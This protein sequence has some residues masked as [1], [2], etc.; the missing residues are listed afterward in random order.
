MPFSPGRFAISEELSDELM[1]FE[2]I[3]E[4]IVMQQQQ[5]PGTI[6]EIRRQVNEM[7][8]QLGDEPPI[9]ATVLFHVKQASVP[10]FQ[11]MA[12]VL[13]EKTR[14]LDGMEQFLFHKHNCT[15]WKPDPASAITYLIYERWE[16]VRY[17]RKQW[18]SRH[19]HHFQDNVFPLLAEP[20]GLDF[21]N[22][23]CDAAVPA[24]VAPAPVLRTGQSKCWG[25]DGASVNCRDT[26]QD[27]AVQAGIPWPTERFTDN[28]DGTVTDNRSGLIW[29]QDANFFK[30]VTRE[31]A[32]Q[33]ARELCDGTAGLKD[34][35]NPGDW[36][37]PNVNELQSLLD[38]SNTEGP[39]VPA[40]HPFKHLRAVNYWTAS[41]V[42]LAPALGWYTAMAVGPPV[43][44]LKMNFMHMLPVK[45]ESARV[46]KTGQTKCWDVTGKEIACQGSGMDG[47][48]Q[49]GVA[50]P[51]PRFT[52]HRN[53]TVTDHLTGL[54]WLH[55]ADAFGTLSWQDA[56][57]AC[58]SLADDGSFPWLRDSSKAGDWR[59]PNVH[60]LRS[61]VDYDHH[62]PALPANH[63]FEH[64][65]PSLYWSSTTVASAPNQARFVFIGVG[66][67]V[68]DHK[69]VLLGVWPVK[70]GT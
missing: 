37:L 20:P 6:D 64:V 55:N 10:Q 65:R 53:G 63:P 1:Q 26:G 66:P 57:D 4:T 8:D 19:L 68:W 2:L 23:Y 12:G 32:L 69:G 45:G 40:K 67:S 14:R 28:G 33:N 36:R 11:E 18:N 15:P 49:K 61:L 41:S 70:G 58:N 5:L 44:D 56:L 30:E 25:A 42:A 9:A 7:L 21:L 27:G 29:L 59:L 51:D 34:D 16:S 13:T 47:D 24:T 35:S 22:F 38:L 31:Q 54:I 48:L 60:E 62:T 3:R 17:F 39:A 50:W 52:N 43:F 46:A